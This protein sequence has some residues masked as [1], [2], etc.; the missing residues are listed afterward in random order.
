MFVGVGSGG[1]VFARTTTRRTGIIAGVRG[2]DASLSIISLFLPVTSVFLESL[3]PGGLKVGRGGAQDSFNHLSTRGQSRNHNKVNETNL[4]LGDHGVVAVTQRGELQ[5]QLPLQVA[6][7]EELLHAPGGPLVVEAPGLSWV[8]DVTGMKQEAQNPPFVKAGAV[9]TAGQDCL[10]LL[11]L[12][13]MHRHIGVKNHVYQQTATLSEVLSGH[14]IEDV[15]FIINHNL[16]ER[17]H[18][19]IFLDRSVVIEDGQF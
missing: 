5:A 18:V 16:K 11:Q 19:M 1:F 10:H 17:G 14:I 13:E 7:L 4:R 12:R 3:S 9:M 6:L 8:G 2:V 15:A